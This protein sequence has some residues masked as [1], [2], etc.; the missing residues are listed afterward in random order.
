MPWQVGD[1]QV[2]NILQ[3]TNILKENGKENLEYQTDE[4]ISQSITKT[5]EEKLR[6]WV[7]DLSVLSQQ[8]R[9]KKASNIEKINKFLIWDWLTAQK[10]V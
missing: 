5:K 3:L 4:K 9:L 1:L 6:H 10:L 8:S 7:I 2:V